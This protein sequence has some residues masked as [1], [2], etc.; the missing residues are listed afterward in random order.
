MKTFQ[1][2]VSILLVTV[3]VFV[4]GL[5]SYHDVTIH[6]VQKERFQQTSH[7]H[8][9]GDHHADDCSICKFHW[10][11]SILPEITQWH[12]LVEKSIGKKYTALFLQV[13]GSAVTFYS[14][15]APPI[16]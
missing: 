15:R 3:F 13:E 2:I 8:H 1:K 11:Q 6:S 12:P 10:Q 14:L 5:K 7:N 9:D 16:V 4:S